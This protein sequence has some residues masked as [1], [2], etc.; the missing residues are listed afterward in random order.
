M[1]ANQHKIPKFSTLTGKEDPHLNN[2]FGLCTPLQEK[3]INIASQQLLNILTGKFNTP[4][5]QLTLTRPYPTCSHRTSS[6]PTCQ[7][8]HLTNKSSSSRTVFNLPADIASDGHTAFHTMLQ[9]VTKHGCKPIPVKVDSGA[10]INTVPLSKYKKLFPAHV[11]KS[12]NLKSKALYPTTNKWAAHDMTPQRFLGY[13]I[14]DIQHKSQPDIL[15]V[16]FFVFKDNT[17]PQILLSYSAFIRLGIMEFKVPNKAP[18]TALDAITQ[19]KKCITFS[20]P[21]HSHTCVK[22]KNKDQH[23][24][25]PLKPV[26]K[27]NSFQDHHYPDI[28]SK[29]K[30]FQDHLPQESTYRQFSSKNDSFQ[31]H[32]RPDSSQQQ[33]SLQNQLFQDHSLQNTSSCNC[34]SQNQLFQDHPSS[35]VLS[36]RQSTINQPF[37]DHFTTDHVRD[38][39][40][41]KHSFPQSFDRVGSLPGTYTICTDPS[42]PPVQ[43]A[44]RKVPIEYKEPI[45]AALQEMVDLGII[46]SV[47][48]PTEW[49]SSLTY[50]RKPNGS[51]RI[52]L[53]PRDLNK[54][55][56]REHYKAPTL[57]E[58]SHKLSG[59]TVFSKLDAKDSFWSIH[60]DTPSSYLTTFNTHK[61]RYRFLRMPFGLKMS[62]DVFQMHMDQLTDRLPGII[63]IHDDICVY[64][65]TQEQH[66]KHLLQLM[67]TAAKQG[68]VFN[69]NKCHIS[70]P[71]ITFYGTIFSA[72]GIKPDP[73]K[74]QALQDLPTPQTQKQLQSFLGHVNYLQPFLPGIASKTT[75]LCK[76][77]S[78]WDWNPST[79]NSFQKLKQWICNTLLKTTLAY[80]DRH[81]PL[82]VHTDA[83]EY[84]LGAAL[85]QNNRPIAFASKTLTDVET[86]YANIERECLS[87][88]FGL[89][90]FHTCIYGR[91]ITVYNDHKPLEMITMKPIHA[92]P[93]RLQC[94]LLRLQHYDYTLLYKPGKEMVLADRL[95]RFPSR[96]ETS[97]I[98]LHQNI[99]HVSFTPN[100]IY[101][102]RGALERD[103]ILSIVY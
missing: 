73:M 27:L 68:L 70:Q 78:Q 7:I 4:G 14:A 98:E 81:Q 67:K 93:P 59:A 42:I 17:S 65:K 43:H 9:M 23:H 48:E 88:V 51:L 39:I 2:S 50:P 38:I 61:G 16:R 35:T 86:H 79:D 72:Q 77:I 1:S 94:M 19:H 71:Q 92:A 103:P 6:P 41:L 24:I 53:N 11:T 56:I 75:F 54:A 3:T 100:T 12:G 29:N 46:T 96:K 49:V 99:Q 66:D 21:L 76:Q 18:V 8:S 58:I 89:E 25:S 22:T 90:R 63:A 44:H 101:T 83:S 37:Q 91:H 5:K 85:L 97:P 82:T 45:E 10:E 87:V 69:S 64:S 102:L 95:S 30:S 32:F 62:Q 60:L 13:F 31:D 80:Y 84:G 40:T 34:F 33:Y 15:Q 57:E 28:S 74:I 20:N 36:Q 47:T 26:I 52:C 55:I